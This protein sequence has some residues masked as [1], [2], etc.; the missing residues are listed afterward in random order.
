MIVTKLM[1][2]LGNQMF[3][4]AVARRLGI[5]RRTQ[6]YM[7][8]NWFDSV[9]KVDVKRVYELDCFNIVENFIPAS[10]FRVVESPVSLKSKLAGLLISPGVTNLQLYRERAHTFDKTVLNLP[11][12][13]YLDGFWQ[14]EK[15]FADV[16]G[17]ILED[18]SYK[19]KPSTRN[20]KLL[21]LI[22]RTNAVS[23]H[24]RRGDYAADAKTKAFHGLIGLD[25]YRKAIELIEKKVKN[26]QFFV[27][28]DDPEWCKQNLKINYPTTY[29]SHNKKGS[30]DMRL[31]TSCEHHIIANSTFSWWGAWLN[32]SK[33]KLV[34]APNRWFTDPSM[35][36]KD[37]LPKNWIKL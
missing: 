24:V 21:D 15:Y 16:R 6:V 25:Y 7:D 31:M 23:L 35:N 28:S 3:Q 2:G 9:A 26:P 33:S 34:Y 10:R 27:F 13:I 14:T 1:G 36:A 20:A 12:N 11:N 18:F 8:L 30:D 37:V 29:I 4:Y 32:P 17:T 22:G 19:D 5:K